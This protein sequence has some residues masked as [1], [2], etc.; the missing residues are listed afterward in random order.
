MR[1][2]SA[3]LVAG[4]AL[5]SAAPIEDRQANPCFIIGNTALPKEV[6][7]VAKTLQ[8][9]ITC[10]A[11]AKTLSGVPDLTAGGVSFSSVD[12]TGKGTPLAF[13]LDKF[14]TTEPLAQNDL[15]KFQAELDV[16][17][18]TEAG[19]RSV[20]GNVA[21]IKVPKFFLSM[22]VSRIQT[23]QGNPPKAAGLQVDHLLGKVTKNAPR[24]SKALLDQ[25]TQL[26]KTLS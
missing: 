20:G 22:Q 10:S 18:A 21:A 25:V 3:L 6:S 14:K 24:E 7:D 17:T 12:F 2:F 9:R 15:K 19:I 1:F 13:A 23:A 8:S 16:Y 4:A 26:A 5:V 11:N